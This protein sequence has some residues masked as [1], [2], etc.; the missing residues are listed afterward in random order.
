[1]RGPRGYTGLLYRSEAQEVG[2][3]RCVA[4]VEVMVE[5]GTIVR[6]PER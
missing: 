4:A 1:M 2:K 6:A 3:A 5:V